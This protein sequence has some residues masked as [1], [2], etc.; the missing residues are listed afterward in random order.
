MKSI[1]FFIF[2]FF[3]FPVFC[4]SKNNIS[5]Y[6]QIGLSMQKTDANGRIKFARF[7]SNEK[8]IPQNAEDFFTNYLNKELNDTFVQNRFKKS[9]NG[10]S[11]ERYQQY[12]RGVQVKEGHYNFRIQNGRMKIASG[13]YVDVTGINPIPSITEEDAINQYVSYLEIEKE[14]IRESSTSLLIKEIPKQPKS[15]EIE[16]IALV[17]QVLIKRVD[18]RHVDVGYIDA[19]DG[20]LL[21][22]VDG[23]YYSS[24]NGYFYTH[25]NRNNNDTPKRGITEY[26][27][28]KF[29]LWDK[30]RG[31]GIRTLKNHP[32][33]PDFEDYDNIWTRS[34]LGVDNYALDVHWTLEQIYDWLSVFFDYDSYDGSSGYIEAILDSYASSSFDQYENNFTFGYDSTSSFGPFASIDIVGHEFGHAILHHTTGWSSGDGLQRILHEGFAD[35]WGIIFEAHINPSADIWKA[36]EE[37][38]LTLSCI[39]DFQYPENPTAYLQMLSTYYSDINYYNLDEHIPSGFFSHWF[40]LLSQGGSGI[41]GKGDSYNVLPVSVD[42][43]EQLI[44]YTTLTTAYLEDCECFED[45]CSAFFDAAVD[46][47]D[48]YLADQVDNAWYA[49]GLIDEPP[50]IYVLNWLNPPLYYVNLDIDHTVRWSFTN[51]GLTPSPTLAVNNA[52]NSCRIYSNYAY[53]GILNASISFWGDS[54]PIVTYSKEVSGGPAYLPIGSLSISSLDISH[55]LITLPNNDKN[56]HLYE[57]N[58]DLSSDENK[59]LIKIYNVSN[60]QLKAIKEVED[61]RFVLDTSSWESGL[62]I[63]QYVSKSGMYSAKIMVR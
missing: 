16:R 3:A 6:E 49:V 34:E 10:M 25:Y 44:A 26:D 21:F 61:E 8:S 17:Y 60:Q 40:Y 32:L 7:S 59:N 46:M 52:D 22:Q 19:H 51:T 56:N 35:I 45:V 57:N 1:L 27:S 62:Y 12:Y 14:A 13:H 36:G 11:F 53:N 47:G 39:N 55:Y 2:V 24:A 37:I 20:Q 58:Q 43:A 15:R 48:W 23:R 63:I 28:G 30:T 18:G 38:T 41:N 33:Y 29:T 9:K 4:P 5:H 42:V 50:H 54:T 31:N